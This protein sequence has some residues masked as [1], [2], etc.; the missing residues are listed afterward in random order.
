MSAYWRVRPSRS[1][2]ARATTALSPVSMMVFLTPSAWS[3][4]TIVAALGPN[5]VGVGDERRE[6]AVDRDIK[7]GVALLSMRARSLAAASTSMPL[8]RMKRSLP[9][10][11]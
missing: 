8:W 11:T 4:S 2:T 5:L 6:F 3:R 9:T 7:A 10:W 1:P